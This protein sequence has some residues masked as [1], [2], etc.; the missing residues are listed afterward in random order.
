MPALRFFFKNLYDSMAKEV[1]EN[2]YNFVMPEY[3]AVSE[4][5]LKGLK[6]R[7]GIEVLEL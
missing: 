5:M 1:T 6:E 2:F 7:Y 4:R 3:E